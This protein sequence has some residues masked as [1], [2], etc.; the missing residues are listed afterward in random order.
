MHLQINGYFYSMYTFAVFQGC[1]QSK[2]SEGDEQE[3]EQKVSH[4]HRDLGRGLCE[5]T[6]SAQRACL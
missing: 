3:T 4:C 6:N 1:E 2:L 5:R